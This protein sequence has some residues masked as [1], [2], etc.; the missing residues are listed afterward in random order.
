MQVA[1]RKAGGEKVGASGPDAER[2]NPTR[3]PAG[4]GAAIEPGAADER[5]AVLGD[6]LGG[7][8]GGDSQARGDRFAQAVVGE[9][10]DASGGMASDAKGS[11]RLPIEEDLAGAEGALAGEEFGQF[12]L[13]VAVDTGDADDLAGIEVEGKVVN[14]G[15]APIT[16]R[17]D[18]A[19]G[20]D[21]SGG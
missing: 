18:G 2:G 20:D 1:A 6:C 3:S 19:E 9:I 4:D 7:E 11:R 8:V 12:A 13:A 15:S 10:G 21:R 5:G 17:G 14:S 16:R